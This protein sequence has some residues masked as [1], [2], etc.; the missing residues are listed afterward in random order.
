VV[1]DEVAA[2]LQEVGDASGGS[3]KS[4][5][6]DSCSGTR[7]SSSAG[8]PWN[9]STAAPPANSAQGKDS[10]ELGEARGRVFERE[11]G[12]GGL[13]EDDH[14]TEPSLASALSLSLASVRRGS[15]LALGERWRGVEWCEG[16]N[17]AG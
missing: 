17:G 15:A 7:L 4:R 14:R 1:D 5:G 8:A 10:Q 13:G 16:E 3:S 9:S 12:Q 6:A 11:R 2:G